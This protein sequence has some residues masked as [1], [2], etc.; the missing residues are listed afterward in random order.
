MKNEINWELVAKYLSGECSAQESN[1][2]EKWLSEA[3]ENRSL[4]ESMK[5]VWNTPGESFE[6]SDIK[7]LWKNVAEK[8]GI[9]T[10]SDAAPVFVVHPEE[11]VFSKFSRIYRSTAFR[12]AAV[13]LFIVSAS[14]IYFITSGRLGSDEWN[15]I[16]VK[17]GGIENILLNDG[18][19]IIAD[20]GSLVQYTDNYGEESRD[21]KL[22][23]QAYFELNHNPDIPFRVHSGNALIEVLGTKF[24]VRSW[25]ESENI[26]VA[27]VEGK[28]MDTGTFESMFEASEFIRE[29]EM[30]SKSE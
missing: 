25:K 9:K 4:L 18:S 24:S 27:V 22:E 5:K 1:V 20:A 10:G 15:S 16:I 13:L 12:Y 26:S 29:R 30:D 6:S 8:S 11:N 2:V 17:N 21:I 23:G 14:L 28:W 19:K 3:E 7:A